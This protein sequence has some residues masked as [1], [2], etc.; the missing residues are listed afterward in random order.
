MFAGD[1]D[2][3]RDAGGV[4]AGPA[5]AALSGGR[6]ESERER[7]GDRLDPD[8][9]LRRC[10]L[11]QVSGAETPPLTVEVVQLCALW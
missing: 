7:R 10:R 2:V 9:P 6:A 3:P 8:P 4:C 11:L 1:G 5:C